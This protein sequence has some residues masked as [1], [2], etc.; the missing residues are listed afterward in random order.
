MSLGR[1]RK[2]VKKFSLAILEEW[3]KK[4]CTFPKEE[5]T[6]FNFLKAVEKNSTEVSKLK[7]RRLLN[8]NSKRF[9]AL[10]GMKASK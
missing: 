3:K 9:K 1:R 2:N 8:H 7:Q 6:Y 10:F 5:K 4:S